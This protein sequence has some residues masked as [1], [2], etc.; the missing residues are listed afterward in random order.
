MS[1]TPV[2]EKNT[3]LFV[4][5]MGCICH[6][7]PYDCGDWQGYVNILLQQQYCHVLTYSQ[8]AMSVQMYSSNK[9]QAV[10]TALGTCM[11]PERSGTC[12]PPKPPGVQ[13]A[14]VQPS[15][16]SHQNL[17]AS[18][19]KKGRKS[20]TAAVIAGATAA[21]TA[22][23]VAALLLAFFLH[24]RNCYT[25]VDGV[26]LTWCPSKAWLWQNCLRADM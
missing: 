7:A 25:S 10:N 16:T 8:K 23:V 18:E 26:T 21:A 6:Y 3:Q 11:T 22:A 4:T 1:T 14:G 20:K 15:P 9:V 5:T 24:R 2:R 19:R 13:P 17:S 12:P